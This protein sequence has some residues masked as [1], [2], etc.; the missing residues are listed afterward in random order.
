MRWVHHPFV[1]FLGAEAAI[2]LYDGCQLGILDGEL[3]GTAVAAA[4]VGSDLS[5]TR[6]VGHDDG[7]SMS[8]MRCSR[9]TE[10]ILDPEMS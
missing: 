9:L 10:E 8:I 2:A 1:T 5:R 6:D 7:W 3:E 4:F